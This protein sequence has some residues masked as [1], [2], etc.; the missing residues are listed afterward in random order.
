MWSFHWLS[1]RTA[2]LRVKEVEQ[3]SCDIFIYIQTCITTCCITFKYA[4][5]VHMHEY[6]SCSYLP[7]AS[8]VQNEGGSSPQSWSHFPQHESTNVSPLPSGPVPAQIVLLTNQRDGVSAPRQCRRRRINNLFA[9]Q[10]RGMKW[11]AAQMIHVRTPFCTS[12]SN[13]QN[14]QQ[15]LQRKSSQSFWGW[16]SYKWGVD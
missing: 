3:M 10:L 9:F 4:T 16:W 8:S 12:R 11:M 13:Q 7:A 2:Y 5:I 15:C 1:V 6:V 14:P